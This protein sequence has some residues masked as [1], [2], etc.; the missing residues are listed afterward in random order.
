L[1]KKELVA[2]PFT[3]DEQDFLKKTIDVRGG[4]SGPPRYDGWYPRLIYRRGD[5]PPDA[6]KPTVADVHTNVDAVLEVGVGDVNFLIVAVDNENDRMAYVGPV[7]SYYEFVH[8]AAARM[9]DPEWAKRLQQQAKLPPRPEWTKTFVAP[10]VQRDLEPAPYRPSERTARERAS[11]GRIRKLNEMLAS[12]RDP[13]TRKRLQDQISA[14][15]AES[16]APPVQ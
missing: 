2:K 6:W 10:A 8:P 5:G 11:D 13:A 14:A 4:G 12:T 3:Q 15:M 16:M 9:T 7:F 1:Q